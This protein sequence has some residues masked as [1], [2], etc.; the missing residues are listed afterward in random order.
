M[1]TLDTE[2]CRE[3]SGLES[4]QKIC[5]MRIAQLDYPPDLSH[6]S[7]CGLCFLRESK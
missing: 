6:L 5:R 2:K 3:P 7:Y 4:S 1:M